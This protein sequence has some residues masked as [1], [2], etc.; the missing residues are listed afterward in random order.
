MTSQ[1]AK[2]AKEIKAAIPPVVRM[3][4]YVVSVVTPGG[5]LDGKAQVSIKVG[6]A[7]LPLPYSDAYPLG[8]TPAVNDVVEV[9]F[10]SGAGYILGRAIGLPTI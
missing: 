6:T 9:L 1:M 2:A 10:V 3:G 4:Q 7:D 5:S 8:G